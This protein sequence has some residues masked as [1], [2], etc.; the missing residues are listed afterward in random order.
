MKKSAYW[1][2]ISFVIGMLQIGEQAAYGST[3]AHKKKKVAIAWSKGGGAHKSMLDALKNYLCPE[4]D[5]VAFNPLEKVWGKLDPV[6]ALSFGYMDSED[7]YNCLLARDCRWIIN[8]TFFFGISSMRRH[9]RYLEDELEKYLRIEKPDLVISVIPVLNYALNEAARRLNIPFLLIAPDCDTSRYLTD[10]Y[11][12]RPFYC[13]LPFD[14]ELLRDKAKEAW[15]YPYFI[16]AYGFPLRPDFFQPK[17]K[18]QIRKDFGVPANKPVVMM[19][20]GATGSSKSVAYLKHIAKMDFSLHLLICI[21]KNEAIR[22][23]I[24]RIKFPP[25]VTRSI[26]GFTRR[27][28][29]LM[30]ISDV[31]ITKAGATTLVEAI[32]MQ[33]PLLIDSV[34]E[35]LEVERMQPEIVKK[36]KLGEVLT[37]YNDLPK[38]LTRMLTDIN[39]KTSIREHMAP[40]SNKKFPHKIKTLIRHILKEADQERYTPEPEQLFGFR[41]IRPG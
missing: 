6:R 3:I 37:S 36:H 28:S 11:P 24:E 25:N 9:T 1:I 7:F 35:P 5:L 29:D 10:M 4:Y 39:Y 16:K 15:I 27:I 2:L 38:K 8:K 30:A 12:S 31:L 21:G 40:L 19:L 32:E 22:K 14:D 41:W 20:M 17:D 18:K 33:V 26:I 23:S 13:T 34:S